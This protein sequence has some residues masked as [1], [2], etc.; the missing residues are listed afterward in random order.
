MSPDGQRRDLEEK[1]ADYASGGVPEYWIIDPQRR[2]VTVLAL[3]GGRYVERGVYR[4]GRRATS[5]LLKGFRVDVTRLF[6]AA[7]AARRSGASDE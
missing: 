3:K 4:E 5:L 6:K 7:D 1:R 2:T